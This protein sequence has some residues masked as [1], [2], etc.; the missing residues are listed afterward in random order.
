MSKLALGIDMGGTGIK[1]GL[2]D[3]NGKLIRTFRL[4][5]PAHHNPEQII[6]D[7]IQQSQ[8]LIELA[9][10]RKIVGIGV[11]CAGDID[12]VSGSVR[13]SPNLGWKDVPLKALLKKAL[14]LPILVDND[15]NVAAWAAYVV[16]AKRKPQNLLCVT[17]GT[18]VGGGLVLQGKL[19]HGA[20]GSAGEIG[21]MTLIPEGLPCACGNQGCTER[22][23]GAKAMIDEAKHAIESGEKTLLKRMIENDFEKLSPYLVQKAAR[24][25]DRLALALW[26]QA[27]ERLGIILAS[28][29]N[30]LNPDW[31]VFAGGLSRAGELLLDP[32]RRTIFKRSFQ[33]PAKAVRLVI[34]KLDQDLGMVGAGLLAHD[35]AR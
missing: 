11:G 35:R 22:Y 16:E 14:K 26:E 9:R 33:T 5:T 20:T 18:G 27:G 21:H 34:S 29:V 31:I 3:Q 17:V 15:A 10:P 30:L 12:P 28:T 25:G 4:P 2:V 23:I 7:I 13:V 24:Q 8:A 1:L 19:Y 32:I 6:S